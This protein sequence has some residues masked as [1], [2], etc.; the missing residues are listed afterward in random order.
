M[1]PTS[2]VDWSQW[3]SSTADRVW[4]LVILENLQLPEQGWKI[5]LL[6]DFRKS[7]RIARRHRGVLWPKSACIADQRTAADV[8]LP[9][10]RFGRVG[11]MLLRIFEHLTPPEYGC[12]GFVYFLAKLATYPYAP[13]ATA[14][15]PTRQVD[16]LGLVIKHCPELHFPGEQNLCPATNWVAEPAGVLAALRSQRL[17]AGTNE[18]VP[19]IGAERGVTPSHIR[20]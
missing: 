17:T 3:R 19:L 6:G 12:A 18:Y 14:A 5:H 15:T 7:P 1:H 10:I 11:L 16:L 4:H 8:A 9:W 2:E 20:N 13:A